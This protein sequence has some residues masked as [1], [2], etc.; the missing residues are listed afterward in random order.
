MFWRWVVSYDKCRIVRSSWESKNF[1]LLMTFFIC[2][3][4]FCWL[5]FCL[6]LPGGICL[7]CQL[8]CTLYASVMVD[9]QS[10]TLQY[11]LCYFRCIFC[12]L[13]RV[14]FCLPSEAMIS[15][16]QLQSVIKFS[17]LWSLLHIYVSFWGFLFAHIFNAFPSPFSA[18][19]GF[20]YTLFNSIC[21]YCFGSRML[22]FQKFLMV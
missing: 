1:L 21:L 13:H 20:I 5:V 2:Y 16:F 6:L 3:N 22:C 11:S 8:M 19:L 4:V 15:L 18:V 10:F 7:F 14:E 9:S 17:S 12:K